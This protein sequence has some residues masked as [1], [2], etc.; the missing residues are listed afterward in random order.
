MSRI[1]LIQDV[2]IPEVD[3]ENKLHEDMMELVVPEQHLD[4]E[5]PSHEEKHNLP[6]EIEMDDIQ[7]TS[8]QHKIIMSSPN[9]ILS[10]ST[11]A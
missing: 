2:N 5:N 4:E 1:V 6:G 3:A 9:I 8:G 11:P 10:F 7:V